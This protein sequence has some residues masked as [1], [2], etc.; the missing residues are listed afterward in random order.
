MIY[1][2]QKDKD[3]PEYTLTKVYN[4]LEHLQKFEKSSYHS[5]KETGLCIMSL[6]PLEFDED[7]E[8]NKFTWLNDGEQWFIFIDSD[9]ESDLYG[10][11]EGVWIQYKRDEVLKNLGL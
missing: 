10:D 8:D 7:K 5:V 4:D 11:A 9:R 6:F 2:F 3:R 1:K